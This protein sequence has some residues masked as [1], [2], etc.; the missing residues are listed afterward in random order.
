VLVCHCA[1]VTDRDVVASI[2]AGA[3]TVAEIARATSAGR[4]CGGCVPTL[5]ALACEHCPLAGP[6]AREVQ[7]ASA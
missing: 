3:R 2:S 6:S 5:R 1:V 4:R 7:R